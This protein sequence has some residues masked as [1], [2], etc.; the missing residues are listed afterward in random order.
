MKRRFVY[1]AAVLLCAAIVAYG[2]PQAEGTK[3]AAGPSKIL[4]WSH[5][6]NEPAKVKA[7]E[8]IAAD[9]MVAHPQVKIEIVWYDKN[10]LRDAFRAA[11][12]AGGKEVADI[13]TQD[14]DLIPQLADAGWIAS[15]DALPKDRFVSG[16]AE[17]GSHKGKLY[18]FNIGKSLNMILYNKE[19][20]KQ[21]GIA[22]PAS[23]QF[24]AAEYLETVKK[25]S[26]AGYA[27]AANAIG[28][29][30]DT[31]AHAVR[32]LTATMFTDAEWNAYWAGKRSWDSPEMREALNYFDQLGKNGFWPPTFTTMTIDEYHVYFHTQRKSLYLWVPSWYTGR[33]FK[34]EDQGGQSPNFRFGMLLNPK[35][36]G[37]KYPGNIGVNFESGY[38]VGTAHPEKRDVAID[39]LRFMMQPKYGAL[40]E[41]YTQI[42][43][44]VK[45]APSDRPSDVPA[46]S[47]G[48][49]TDEIARV[50]GS[51]PATLM[52]TS[53][54]SGDLT[55]AITSNIS[56]GITQK[57]VTVDQAIANI[58]K[59]IGK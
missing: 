29:R 42:P 43:A 27:G 48:W 58:N 53:G 28:N 4:W 46:G 35:L 30:P 3:A 18:K 55:N 17:S 41:A 33:A 19:I 47:W 14:D 45:N 1:I 26:A 38:A 9:Y 12:T 49:Y 34:P 50:Y 11:M 36:P 59:V 13:V 6:A 7:I 8:K 31:A 24:G 57:L 10:P 40:W 23:N 15:L 44:A 20:M 22:V 39:I 37:A 5:W 16:A 51:A 2:S 54:Q 21:L 52:N 32:N 56:Q 25:A